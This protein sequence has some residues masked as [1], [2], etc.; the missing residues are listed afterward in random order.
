MRAT[1]LKSRLNEVESVLTALYIGII[2]RKSEGSYEVDGF[3]GQVFAGSVFMSEALAVKKALELAKVLG[4]GL[5]GLEFDYL[6]LVNCL[7]GSSGVGEWC[8]PVVIEDVPAPKEEFAS[9]SFRW[10]LRQ[11]KFG[12]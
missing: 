3:Y 6:N 7:N 5:L 1:H 8:S 12:Y 11:G 9:F 10:S 4:F 2:F